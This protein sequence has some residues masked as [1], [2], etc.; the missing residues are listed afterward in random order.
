MHSTKFFV[1]LK[2][3]IQIQKKYSSVKTVL[4]KNNTKRKEVHI[5][6]SSQ[7]I[8]SLTHSLCLIN[9]YIKL[10]QHLPNWP[11]VNNTLTAEKF[12]VDK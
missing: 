11:S 10:W 1:L 12:S 2:F 4:P 9:D 8:T 7:C 6:N 5:I 3:K